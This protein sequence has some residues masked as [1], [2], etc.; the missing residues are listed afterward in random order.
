MVMFKVEVEGLT[1]LCRDESPKL[2]NEKHK[3]QEFSNYG[4]KETQGKRFIQECHMSCIA[5]HV[6]FVSLIYRSQEYSSIKSIKF[7]NNSDLIITNYK[8][9]M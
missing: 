1:R 2:R 8:C 6:L 3:Q 5:R 9:K 4:I 7:L